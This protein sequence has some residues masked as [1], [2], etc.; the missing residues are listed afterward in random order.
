MQASEKVARHLAAWS[1]SC[2]HCPRHLDRKVY[3]PALKVKGQLHSILK[4]LGQEAV[5]HW[6]VQTNDSTPFASQKIKYVASCAS[7]RLHH[8]DL[9]VAF[10]SS[11]YAKRGMTVHHVGINGVN[12]IEQT[13]SVARFQCCIQHTGAHVYREV[14]MVQTPAQNSNFSAAVHCTTCWTPN[15]VDFVDLVHLQDFCSY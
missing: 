1:E 15:L 2:D 5:S 7:Q 8:Y 14:Q 12:L 6:K 9:H 3:V 4:M 11:L 13:A 10:K